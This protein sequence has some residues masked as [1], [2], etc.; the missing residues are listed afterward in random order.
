MSRQSPNIFISAGE[1]SGDLH[2]AELVKALKNYIPHARFFGMGDSAMAD[3][4]VEL[5]ATIRDHSAIGMW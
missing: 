2:A 4:G 1:I 5:I 3:A